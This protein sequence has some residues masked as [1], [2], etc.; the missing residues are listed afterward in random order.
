MPDNKP[1]KPARLFEFI[2]M[3]NY[4]L[5]AG[6]KNKVLARPPI[7]CSRKKSWERDHE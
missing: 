5:L 7:V 3:A 2:N 6:R 1:G 4:E